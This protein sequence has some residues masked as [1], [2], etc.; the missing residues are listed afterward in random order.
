MLSQFLQYSPKIKHVQ[1]LPFVDHQ[2][3]NPGN[4]ENF[5][6]VGCLNGK[7]FFASLFLKSF[8]DLVK[9]II[10]LVIFDTN[11]LFKQ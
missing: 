11:P 3:S 4:S 9:K 8:K 7:N 6:A 5:F 2:S 10:S 1:E